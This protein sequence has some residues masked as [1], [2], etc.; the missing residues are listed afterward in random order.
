MSYPQFI[1]PLDPVNLIVQRCPVPRQEAAQRILIVRLG[2][3][4]DILMATPLLAALRRSYPN[5]HLTWTVE[6]TAVDSISAHPYVD[7]LLVWNSGYWRGKLVPYNVKMLEPKRF[8]ALPWL[9]QSLKMGSQLRG[10]RYDTL[11]SLQPEEWPTLL[12]GVGAATTIGVFDTFRQFSGLDYTS[13]FARYYN[14]AYTL[15]DLP[16]HRTDQY[17][18]A[19]KALSL[20]PTHDKQMVLG[21]TAEDKQAADR[22]LAE[23]GLPPNKPFVILAPMTTWK[24]RNWPAENYVRLAN[25]LAD[26]GLP[27]MLISSP[28]PEERKAVSAM[29]AQMQTPPIIALGTLTFRQI[30]ALIAQSSLVISGDTGPMHVAAAVG[31]RFVGIFG[32]TA[33]ANLAPLVGDGLILNHAVPCGPCNKDVCR[34]ESQNYLR[35]LRL[36]TV[37][38]VIEAAN[39][40]LACVPA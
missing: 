3:H 24:S 22:F 18:L 9:F 1:Q 32:P 23:Q 14:H 33:P 11:I 21:Y 34:Q 28:N 8:L 36:V 17:L 13:P 26:R 16:A 7:E 40:L 20:P 10:R 2:S 4:G 12:L 29:A 15:D 27:I 39:R 37:E 25:A 35:C 38:E 19:L 5:A 6:Y 31:T 30:A